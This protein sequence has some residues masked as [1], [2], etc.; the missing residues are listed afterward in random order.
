MQNLSIQGLINARDLGGLAATDGRK[1]R[2]HRLIRADAL[3][4]LTAAG[5]EKLR[6]Y[7]L[8]TVI[9]LR[10]ETERNEKPDPAVPGAAILHIPIFEEETAG[11]TREKDSAAK[12]NSVPDMSRLYRHMVS[13]DHSVAQLS[14]VIKAIMAVKDGCVLFHC[15]AGKDR[16]GLVAMLLLGILG[17]SDEDILEDYIYTN[18]TGADVAYA[19]RD[20]VLRK[21]G[22]EALAESVK[23]AF[24]ADESYLLGAMFVVKECGGY[25]QFFKERLG[26]SEE[27]IESFR[28][29]I[30]ET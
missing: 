26:I 30:A 12:M 4:N 2:R 8:S 6:D 11:I 1:I 27:K 19:Y 25:T 15:T 24:L 3:N 16:T 20:M 18:V 23:R 9:D 14:K 5:I 17:V 7:G 13:D 10:T 29:R 22:N 28:N 21:T